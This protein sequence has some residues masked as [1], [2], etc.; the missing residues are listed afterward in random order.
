MCRAG[1]ESMLLDQETRD[2]QHAI[3]AVTQV[4]MA[5]V[6]AGRATRTLTTLM[7][8]RSAATRALPGW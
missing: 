3:Q 7:L 1:R 4:H 2:V 5:W 6:H 8:D